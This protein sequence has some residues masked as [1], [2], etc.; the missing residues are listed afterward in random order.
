MSNV[1]TS[2]PRT[3]RFF[4]VPATRLVRPQPSALARQERANEQLRAHM[5]ALH[6]KAFQHRPDAD[7]SR[8]QQLGLVMMGANLPAIQ[9]K[10]LGGGFVTMTPA[11]AT[12][13]FQATAQADTRIFA[14]AELHRAALAALTDFRA[15]DAYDF[16]GGWPEV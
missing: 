13:I 7:Y 12:G 15:I 5:A 8:I 4:G 14:A 1:H 10:T 6:I 11:L 16:S 3:A 2:E 9:W